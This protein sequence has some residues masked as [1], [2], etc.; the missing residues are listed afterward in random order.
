[1]SGPPD[2]R[3]SPV[4]HGAAGVVVWRAHLAPAAD[5]EATAAL[6]AADRRRL[7]DLPAA[8]GRRLVARRALL[9]RAA[10]DLLGADP[11]RVRALTG[12][13]PRR[14]HV[15]DG[16]C[17]FVSSSSSGEEGLLALAD[18]P[19][20]VDLERLPGPPDARDVATA[21][22]PPP[23]RAWVLAGDADLPERLL[24][25]WVRKEAVV[26][27]T[28]EGLARDLTTFVV[29]PVH[30]DAAVLSSARELHGLRTWDVAAAGH[31]A[32]LAVAAGRPCGEDRT[33]ASR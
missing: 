6:E 4:T 10:A 19:V 24:A 18:R 8:D 22:L 12:A 7:A 17:L 33:P 9:R 15:D 2:E 1:M 21:L 16:R 27:A 29:D 20:G 25:V 26:K 11:S 23:E 14:V 31:A 13:G 5:D 32:A 3:L 30:D 28:G